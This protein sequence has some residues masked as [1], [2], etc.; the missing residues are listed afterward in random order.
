MTAAPAGAGV[1]LPVQVQMNKEAAR[2]PSVYV[3]TQSPKHGIDTPCEENSN[4][5]PTPHLGIGGPCRRADEHGAGGRD[6]HRASPR[7]TQT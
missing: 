1:P 4:T 3:R 7:T 5:T 6:R 2:P